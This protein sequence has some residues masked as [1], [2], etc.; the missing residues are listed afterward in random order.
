MS[1]MKP[2]FLKES[3]PESY[4]LEQNPYLETVSCNVN[5]LELSRYARKHNKRIMDLTKEEVRKFAIK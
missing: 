2:N 3:M 1:E 5:L 4:Y